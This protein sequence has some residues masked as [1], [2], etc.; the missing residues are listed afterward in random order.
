MCESNNPVTP[1][2][3]RNASHKILKPAL[4]R[5][6]VV[7][8]TSSQEDL[9]MYSIYVQAL[10]VTVFNLVNVFR[11]YALSTHLQSWFS[12][13]GEIQT[14]GKSTQPVHVTS[15]GGTE[16]KVSQHTN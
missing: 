2:S 1:Y 5:S 3:K 11:R 15:G 16:I 13:H 10:V 12:H 7:L 14:T 4:L 6:E 9:K 8:K